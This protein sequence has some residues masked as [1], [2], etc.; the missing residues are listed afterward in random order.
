MA[1]KQEG[2]PPAG[3]GADDADLAVEPGLSAQPL[4]C[5]FGVADDL[6]IGDAA[7]GAH[8]GGDVVGFALTGAVVEVMADRGVAVM[9]EPAGGLTIKLVPARR[10]V[11]Q[12]DARIGARTQRPRDIGRNRLTL[13]ASD[14]DCL[15]NHSFVGHCRSLSSIGGK[16]SS[17]LCSGYHLAFRPP[18]QPPATTAS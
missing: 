12:H 7:L 2:L 4:D 11:D 9:C 13:V 8:L 3:A 15:G 10:M 1:G 17:R 6:R 18:A 16:S 14:R 5:T